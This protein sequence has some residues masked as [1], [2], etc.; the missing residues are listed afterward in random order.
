MKELSLNILDI[1]Q[2]SVKANAS[3]IEITITENK[4]TLTLLIS[5]NGH[6]MTDEILK[7][8]TDPFCTTR[9]TRKVGLGIPLLKLS[10]EQTGGYVAITSRHK[11]AFPETHGT[12]TTALFYK[13]HIDMTPLGDISATVT[14]L[15]QC[16]PHLDFVFKHETEKGTVA[17]DTRELKEV[18]GEDVPLNNAQVMAWI[19]DNLSE[20]YNEIN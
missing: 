3:V 11:D 10:A 8:V 19:G 17:L 14:T 6:G 13:T 1:A 7:N 9:T 15:I 16:N 2:N 4:E 18:L 5:D 20:Q 12:E